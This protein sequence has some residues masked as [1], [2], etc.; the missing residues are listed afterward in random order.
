MNAARFPVAILGPT[1][2]GKSTLAMAL[3]PEFNGEIVSCDSMQLYRGLDIGTAKPSPEERRRVRLHLIDCMDVHEPYSAD[4]FVADALAALG[5]IRSRGRR[6]FIVG[7]TG[8][9][10]KALLYGLTPL[11]ADPD[12]MEEL[13][14][15]ATTPEGYDALRAEVRAHCPAAEERLAANPRRLLRAVEVLRLTGDLPAAHARRKGPC[16]AA[17]PDALE[18]VLRPAPEFLRERIARRTALML[19]QGWIDEVAGLVARG[20]LNSPTARQALGYRDIAEFLLD[21]PHPPRPESA[22]QALA[23]RLCQRTNQYARRQRTWFRHQHPK[24]EVVEFG[25]EH[26]WPEVVH[27]IRERVRVRRVRGD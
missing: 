9:Y 7:G 6:A 2:S 25:S 27:G 14:G 8:L 11:P 3:A 4:Q 16:P 23:L 22:V 10:A 21:H 26:Q 20:L 12:L 24:A 13:V 18:L 17:V 1:C 15:I 19:E 5:D